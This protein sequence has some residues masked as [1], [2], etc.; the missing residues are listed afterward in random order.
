MKQMYEAPEVQVIDMELQG[1]IA[2]SPNPE[3]GDFD[4]DNL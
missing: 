2:A 1:M 3:L 4:T